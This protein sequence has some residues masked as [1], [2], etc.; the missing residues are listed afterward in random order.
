MMCG[1]Y[2]GIHREERTTPDP[3]R[4]IL[5]R[6][7]GSHD[8]GISVGERRYDGCSQPTIRNNTPT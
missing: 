8:E 5:G 7:Q 2:Q 3:F 1:I 6:C 4:G